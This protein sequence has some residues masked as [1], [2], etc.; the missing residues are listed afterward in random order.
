MAL[1]VNQTVTDIIT[2]L[3]AQNS[4]QSDAEKAAS[5]A[6]WTAVVTA[7]YNRIKLD[8]TVN[9]GTL[10]LTPSS[11]IAPFGGGPLTGSGIL[12]AGKATV[13]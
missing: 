13:L 3:G 10:A 11:L 7:L 5:T 12:T 6:A 4:N 8:L 1:N 2:A 9:P